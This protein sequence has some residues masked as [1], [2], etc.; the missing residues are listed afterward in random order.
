VC[1]VQCARRICFFG[2]LLY[3]PVYSFQ[4]SNHALGEL[5]WF[6]MTALLGV[7]A[8][9]KC[10]THPQ[11][12]HVSNDYGFRN[13][14]RSLAIVAEILRALGKRDRRCRVVA[15]RNGQ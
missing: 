9:R 1:D 4:V 6:L 15:H 2:F 14:F 8:S 12:R 13:G 10:G 3:D 5:F 11:G 7:T